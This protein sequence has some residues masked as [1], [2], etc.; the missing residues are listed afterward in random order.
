M[1]H[2]PAI[3]C[4][5]FTPTLNPKV[6]EL[7]TYWLRLDSTLD[8]L[9]TEASNINAEF[10]PLLRASLPAPQITNTALRPSTPSSRPIVSPRSRKNSIT[11]SDTL[12][13]P[14]SRETT[15]RPQQSASLS[16]TASIQRDLSQAIPTFFQRVKPVTPSSNQLAEIE[17]I[18][19]SYPNKCVTLTEMT[20]LLKVCEPRICACCFVTRDNTYLKL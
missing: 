9:C 7:F 13:R 16:S 10:G 6:Q 17:R 3:S 18:F 2:A 15:M 19:S 5:R 14:R 12:T 8:L 1:S 11:A 20:P 4:S